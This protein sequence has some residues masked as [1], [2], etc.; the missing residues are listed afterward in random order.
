MDSEV[1]GTRISLLLLFARLHPP[2]AFDFTPPGLWAGPSRT[3]AS[4]ELA[5]VWPMSQNETA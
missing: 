4:S 5:D 2:E 3:L 1:P